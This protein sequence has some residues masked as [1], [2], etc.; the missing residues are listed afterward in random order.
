[1]PLV[2]ADG[3]LIG[4][5]DVDSPVAARFDDE[6]R[7][8]MERCAACSSNTRGKRRATEQRD[9]AGSNHAGGVSSAS[10]RR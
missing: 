4:V 3:T 5:W 8:G 9:A 6:D 2:A 10:A 1:V 7:S